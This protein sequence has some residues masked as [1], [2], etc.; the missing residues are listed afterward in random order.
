MVKYNCNICKYETDKKTDYSRHNKSKRH[1]EKVEEKNIESKL[2]PTRIQHES[3]NKFV[4]IYCNNKYSTQSNM[5]KHMKKCANIVVIEK[6]T[7]IVNVKAEH[8]VE[9]LELLEKRNKELEKQLDTYETMLKSMSTPQT[10]NNFNYICNNYPDTPALEGQKSYSNMIESK[11]LTLM[12]IISMYY[13]DKKLV[14]FLGDYIT[15]LYKKEEPKNQSLWA[16][17]ISRLTYIISE[18]CKK[19]GNVWTYDKKGTRIKKVII[20]PALNFIRDN[21]VAYCQDNGGSSDSHTLKYMIAANGTIEL[22]DSGDLA[23]DIAKYI[24]PEFA[25]KQIEGIN[26]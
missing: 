6:E 4:C 23:N 2:N 25:V 17:D 13:Y 14:P 8:M 10:I 9:K 5:S 1:L 26:E 20:E 12:D 22:I 19:K 16:T 21:L 11:K 3:D 15:R 24:A 7:A 18:S